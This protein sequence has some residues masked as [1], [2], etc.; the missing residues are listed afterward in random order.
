M[1]SN[2]LA[3][4]FSCLQRPPRSL[5]VDANTLHFPGDEFEKKGC[6]G[7]RMIWKQIICVLLWY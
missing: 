1:A 5:F 3:M 6:D 4:P 7:L 2:L